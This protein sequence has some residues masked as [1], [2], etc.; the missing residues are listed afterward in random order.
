[1]T[2]H[3]Q[4]NNRE[5]GSNVFTWSIPSEIGTGIK[6]GIFAYDTFPTSITTNTG[7]RVENDRTYL[8]SRIIIGGEFPDSLDPYQDVYKSEQ[9]MM[10]SDANV[11]PF[12]LVGTSW[13]G[14]FKSLNHGI[15]ASIIASEI[16]IDGGA[17]L[18]SSSMDVAIYP[19]DRPGLPDWTVF[20]VTEWLMNEPPPHFT[21][22]PS[23]GTTALLGLGGLVTLRRRRSI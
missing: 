4:T 16:K 6:M 13:A 18:L 3:A 10:S 23:P 21:V 8:W 7:F 20:M 11:T 22:I 14:T 17:T 2:A 19:T 9:T 15:M 5:F 12:E 1:M